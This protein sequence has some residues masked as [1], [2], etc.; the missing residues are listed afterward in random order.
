VP[1]AVWNLSRHSAGMALRFRTNAREVWVDYDLLSDRLDMPHMPATGVSGTDLY[2]AAEGGALRWVQVSR[3][4]EQHV[5]SQLAAGIDAADREYTLYLPLYNGVDRLRVGVPEGAGLTP[6]DPRANPPI[7]F[8]GTSIMHG[9]CASR[10]GMAIPA[11]VGRRFDRPTIN[12]GFSGNGRMDP[13]VVDLLAEL[14]PA[15]YCIDCLPNMNPQMVDERTVALVERLRKARPDTPILLVEDRVFTNAGFFASR[16]EFHE[17][18]HA[19]LRKAYDT[20]VA[21][22]TGNLHYLPATDLLGDDGDAAVDGS[23]PSD[24]GF[25]RYADAYEKVLRNILG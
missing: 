20:L 21:A 1:E 13:P 5:Q 19:A 11:L 3:P 7:V 22:G 8:Y 16:R 6:L 9:A 17:N 25:V 24:L 2:A 12:L 4:T 23:H 10:P 18:N 15:V 14:D